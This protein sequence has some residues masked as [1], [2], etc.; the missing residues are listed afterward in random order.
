MHVRISDTIDLWQKEEQ[1][2]TIRQ[3]R[4]DPRTVVQEEEEQERET[5]QDEHTPPVGQAAQGGRKKRNKH[6]CKVYVVI[7]IN[8]AS[9]MKHTKTFIYVLFMY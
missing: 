5:L 9:E 3:S 8:I 2:S 7:I 4:R 1:P 6:R